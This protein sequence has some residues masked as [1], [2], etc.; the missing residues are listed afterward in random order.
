MAFSRRGLL[1]K[2]LGL[3]MAGGIGFAAHGVTATTPRPK[4]LLADPHPRTLFNVRR[5]GARGDGHHDDTTSIQTAIN[6]AQK[7]HGTVL[8]PEGTFMV[9]GL[10]IPSYVSI[11]GVG[12]GQTVLKLLPG[13][14]RD[15]VKTVDFDSLTG[16]NSIGGVAGVTLSNLTLDGNRD[17]NGS[18]WGLRRY[19]Y[20]WV[21]ENIEIR[22]MASGG[23]YTEYGVSPKR[24][25]DGDMME[26]SWM[27]VRVHDNAGPGVINHG[28]HDSRVVNL[29]IYANKGDGLVVE[30]Q[31]GRFNGAGMILTNY[32][33]YWNTGV[34][35]HCK[36]TV[37]GT[38]VEA[39][40]NAQGGILLETPG[41]V[42][43]GLLVY[44]NGTANNTK[45]SGLIV[46]SPQLAAGDGYFSGQIQ[47]NS[48]EQLQIVQDSGNNVADLALKAWIPGST[49]WSGTTNAA[50]AWRV[51]GIRI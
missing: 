32:H 35:L 38:M 30:Y 5:Y 36:G 41:C 47:G 43:T 24:T 11:W 10:T 28:P 3:G 21:I 26:D 8:I 42:L 20:R 4:Q 33:A 16:T 17:H 13:V 51:N 31:A 22:Y 50:S 1:A 12:M 25:T 44:A 48:Q 7:V 9:Q 34:G 23:I 15:L 6:Q 2:L 40:S 19:G 45:A 37:F 46:G 49:L 27:D 39:E 29:L 14:N 18:G